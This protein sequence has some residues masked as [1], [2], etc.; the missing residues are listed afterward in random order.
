VLYAV[1]YMKKRE[2]AIMPEQEIFFSESLNGK[3][4]Q[5]IKTYDSQLAREAF[6]QM[7]DNSKNVLKQTLLTEGVFDFGK[8]EETT[9]DDL[10]QGVEDG[11]REDWNSFS[12]FIVLEKSRE[13]SRYLFACSD[14]PTAERVAKL[15]LSALSAGD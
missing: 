11:A 4:V 8:P 3:H 12:Y 15:N 6:E 7:D 14:W 2:E 1:K 5:V 10:W 13:A 9:D